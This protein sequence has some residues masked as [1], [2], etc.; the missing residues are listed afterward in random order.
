[1]EQHEASEAIMACGTDELGY[2]EWICLNGDHIE[3]EHHSCRHRSCPRCH[4]AQ[5]HQWLEM[6]RE[7]LLPCDHY[8]VVITLPHE[9]IPLW[10]YNRHWSVDRLFKGSVETIRQLLSD[11]RYLGGEVGIVAS[12]HT[13]GRTLSAHPHVH[14][15]ITGSGLHQGNCRNSRKDFLLPVGVIKAKFRGKWLSWLNEAYAKEEI[16]LPPSWREAEW[17]A[18]LRQ[19]AKKEWNVR[20]QGAY[21]H[22][23]GV[24]N[25]LSRYVRGGPIKD[26][27]IM[28]A[29]EEGV[30]FRYRDHHDG[31][32]KRMRLSTGHFIERVLW[33][34]PNKG[35]HNVRYYGLYTP[36]AKEKRNKMRELLGAMKSEEKS[37]VIE[38]KERR[39]PKCKAVLFHRKST[40]RKISYI[41]KCGAREQAPIVQQNAEPARANPY[42]NMGFTT[43]AD[44]PV[45]F[46]PYVGWLA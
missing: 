22:G 44:P 41:N 9:L 46:G 23:T 40:R 30:D 10:Q 29:D 45:F 35:Q 26:R 5:T 17:L 7:R 12:L 16:E 18:M 14:L 19:I 37:T 43:Q 36:R 33:H 8:H 11:E 34:V 31:R 1:M 4:G 3:Q 13:W 39:C 20:I 25:Y 28:K 6:M 15:L 21:S 27:R 42:L 38:G 2:E 32:H 24:I